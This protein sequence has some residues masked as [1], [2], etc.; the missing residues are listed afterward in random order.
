MHCI[1]FG[2]IFDG[3]SPTQAAAL[4]TL[5][6]IQYIGSVQSSPSTPLDNFKIITGS[7]TAMTT[8]LQQALDKIME[9]G[10]QVVLIK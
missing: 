3:S 4:S 9:D 10:V 7:P 2:P 6:E 5:Q 8:N 1:A